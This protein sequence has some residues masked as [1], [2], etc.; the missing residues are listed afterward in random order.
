MLQPLLE[1]QSEAFYYAYPKTAVQIS[2]SKVEQPLVSWTYND[3]Y[4][5]ERLNHA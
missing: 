1:N 5:W 4:T 2:Y 3:C